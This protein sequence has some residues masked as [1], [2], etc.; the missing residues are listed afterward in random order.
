MKEAVQGDLGAVQGSGSLSGGASAP[1]AG[2]GAPAAAAAAPSPPVRAAGPA[3]APAAA[4][5]GGANPEDVQ[6]LQGV[7][8]RPAAECEQALQA[9]GGNTD[10]AAALL[11]GL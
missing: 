7:T 9:C 2:A 4:A 1:P 11:L 3:T 5:S 10:A 6:K 8:G